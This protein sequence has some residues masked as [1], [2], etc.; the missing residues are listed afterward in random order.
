MDDSEPEARIVERVRGQPDEYEHADVVV[1][2]PLVYAAGLA[3]WWLVGFRIHLA[4]AGATL[5]A[6]AVLVKALLSNLVR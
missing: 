2:I 5:A 6:L 1:S 3:A 4:L